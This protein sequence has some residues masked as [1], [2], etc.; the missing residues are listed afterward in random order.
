MHLCKVKCKHPFLGFKLVYSSSFPMVITA[1]TCA[2][3]TDFIVYSKIILGVGV[4]WVLFNVKSTFMQII[5]SIS[6]NSV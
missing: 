1:M 4:G 3:I 5:S 6:N 2:T